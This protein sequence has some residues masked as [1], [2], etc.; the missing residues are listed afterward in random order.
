MGRD[1]SAALKGCNRARLHKN[2]ICDIK[3]K[4]LPTCVLLFQQAMM[5]IAN[6]LQCNAFTKFVFTINQEKEKQEQTFKRDWR[7]YIAEE[8]RQELLLQD[9]EFQSDS[10]QGYW[11]QLENQLVGVVDSIAPMTL[12][13]LVYFAKQKI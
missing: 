10:V 5:A 4:C 13:R 8:L 7:G 9:W 12:R 2:E 6:N 1:P 11:N 3:R